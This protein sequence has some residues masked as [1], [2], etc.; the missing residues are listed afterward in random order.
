[1]GTSQVF[2]RLQRKKTAYQCWFAFPKK[3]VITAKGLGVKL[4]GRKKLIWKFD[5]SGEA[6]YKLFITSAGDSAENFML[7]S[8]Y[9]YFPAQNKWKLIGTCRLNGEWTTLKTPSSFTAAPGKSVQAAP[10]NNV[11]YQQ[12]NG[13]WKSLQSADTIAPVLAPFSNTDS[14]KQFAIEK[15][16]L[17]KA[18][19]AGKTDVQE[20]QPGIYY[21]MM[22]TGS[23]R[24]IALTDTVSVFYKGY[25]YADGKIFDQTKDK[26]A[27]FPLSRLIKGWQTGLQLCNV[28][29]KIKLVLLSGQAYAIRTR[30]AKIPPNSILVFEI[31]VVDATAPNQ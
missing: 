25:L 10:V 13:S 7:Y 19:A 30:A 22:K 9:V 16:M 27:R 3:A 31:E 21:A 6:Y 15:E 4:T 28:G 20:Y 8:G 26:P 2:L 12:R 29:G 1:M 24:P 23:G 14:A 11:W 18:V 5:D 17:D